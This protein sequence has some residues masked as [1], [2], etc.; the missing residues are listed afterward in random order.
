MDPETAKLGASLREAEGSECIYVERRI[1]VHARVAQT[2]LSEKAVHVSLEDL[3]SPG[4]LPPDHVLGSP[5]MGTIA[6]GVARGEGRFLTDEWHGTPYCPW[7]VYLG[8]PAVESVRVLAA[9]AREKPSCRRY[10]LLRQRLQDARWPPE[11]DAETRLAQQVGKI[12]SAVSEG[13][14]D[15]LRGARH[16]ADVFERLSL[17]D[18][19]PDFQ[20][21]LDLA[22]GIRGHWLIPKD[23]RERD[24]EKLE[25]LRAL[26]LPWEARVLDACRRLAAPD[27]TGGETTL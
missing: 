27:T 17:D 14:M 15:F 3:E 21:C 22:K 8:H 2:Q 19:Q 1:V 16:I 6:A 24:S 7:T 25:Q 20:A 12:A 10:L 9:Q 23:W 18:G 4:F 11:E 13:E 26:A 5:Y